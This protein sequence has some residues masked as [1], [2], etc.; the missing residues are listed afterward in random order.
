MI[1][2][3]YNEITSYDRFIDYQIQIRRFLLG[4]SLSYSFPEKFSRMILIEEK[5]QS[6]SH[7][8]SFGYFVSV[9]G[10]FKREYSQFLSEDT[11]E[12]KYEKG[13]VSGGQFMLTYGLS[14]L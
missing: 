9:K 7:T 5:S 10:S 12:R 3:L 1:D 14:F 4:L 6:Y 2:R 11:L 8:F 13:K